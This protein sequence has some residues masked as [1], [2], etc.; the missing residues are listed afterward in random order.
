MTDRWRQ[1]KEK[2]WWG[3]ER[4]VRPLSGPDTEWLIAEVARLRG[5]LGE[6]ADLLSDGA[7]RIVRQNATI[8]TLREILEQA[9]KYAISEHA[10]RAAIR[11]AL[12]A[13]EAPQ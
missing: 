3:G 8:A 2:W 4:G 13:T 12:A 6:C 11:A 7:T 1:I 9:D 10:L 5:E